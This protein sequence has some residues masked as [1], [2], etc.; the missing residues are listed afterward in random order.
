MT[1]KLAYNR[2]RKSFFSF[3]LWTRHRQ[4]YLCLCGY[5]R[6]YTNGQ[7]CGLCKAHLCPVPSSP[8]YWALENFQHCANKYSH[9]YLMCGSLKT[10][11]VW[12]V[13]SYLGSNFQET[14][15]RKHMK[16]KRKKCGSRIKML[17]NIWKNG[18]RLDDG[19]RILRMG[20]I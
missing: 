16:F 6:L 3:S 14:I 5:S 20:N 19:S 12:Q 15:L 18:L 17:I 7:A 10:T 1:R 9:S 4:H 11:K 13:R 8:I 2:S